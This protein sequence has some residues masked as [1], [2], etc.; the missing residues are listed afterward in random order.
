MYD[1]KPLSHVQIMTFGNAF[2]PQTG[3]DKGKFSAPKNF[4]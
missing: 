1:S 4:D 2:Q 3:K